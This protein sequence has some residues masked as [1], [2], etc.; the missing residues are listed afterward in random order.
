MKDKE[1]KR[2]PCIQK[3]ESLLKIEEVITFCI[4]LFFLVGDNGSTMALSKIDRKIIRLRGEE[5]DKKIVLVAILA[6]V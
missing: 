1:K 6:S 5:N 3:N 2:K 4:S